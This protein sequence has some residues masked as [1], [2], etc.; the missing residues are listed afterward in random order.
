MIR[1][2][3]EY[4]DAL[5]K[6]KK[7]LEYIEIQKKTLEQTDLS[8]EEI[9][10]AMEP[11]WSFHYQL[12]EGVEYYERIKRGDFEAVINLTQIGRVLIGLRIYRNMSQKTLADLLGVSE[13]Q[14]S[15]DE[16]NEYHGITIE[17]AQKII[18]VL[19][20]NIKLT[21][22]ITTQSPDPNLIAS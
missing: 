3:K 12:R 1:T 5:L 13:A 7:D 4:Q 22:D 14:V 9:N 21:F 18:N 20:V 19:G 6:L 17:K 10:R 8:T 11:V 15:R 2:E 16:R